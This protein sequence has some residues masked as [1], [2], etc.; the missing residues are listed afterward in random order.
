[1]N[2]ILGLKSIKSLVLTPIVAFLAFALIG[3]TVLAQTRNGR[4]Q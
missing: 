3:A 4:V 2:S 1:M